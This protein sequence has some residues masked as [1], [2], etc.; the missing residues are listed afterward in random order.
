MEGG[1]QESH[2]VTG[3]VLSNDRCVFRS[4][5]TIPSIFHFNSSKARDERESCTE[6]ESDEPTTE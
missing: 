4:L 6:R 3:M 1:T 2:R 5:P